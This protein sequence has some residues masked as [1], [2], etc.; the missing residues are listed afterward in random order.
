M[1]PDSFKTSSKFKYIHAD[2]RMTRPRDRTRLDQ[3]SDEGNQEE[4][5]GD[6][7]DIH[8]GHSYDSNQELH[9]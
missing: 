4:T 6:G 2:T 5:I 3:G 9:K 1:H 8:H 7:A